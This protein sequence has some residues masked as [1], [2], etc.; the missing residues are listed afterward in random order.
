MNSRRKQTAGFTLAELLVATAISALIVAFLGSMFVSLANT[1]SK[2][3]QR[4]DVFRDA[5]AA[6]QLIERD[7]TGIVKYEIP[8]ICS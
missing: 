1:G 3:T 4:L 6:L 5:R 7:L 8:R 2:A